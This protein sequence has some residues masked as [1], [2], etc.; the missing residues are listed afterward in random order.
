MYA[1]EASTNNSNGNSLMSGVLY[2]EV[3]FVLIVITMNHLLVSC[4]NL[5]L[6]Y[7]IGIS[8]ILS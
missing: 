5:L 3:H 4:E 7:R 8:I 1:A 2:T 6:D